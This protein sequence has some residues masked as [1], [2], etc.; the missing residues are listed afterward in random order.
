MW[1]H[2]QWHLSALLSDSFSTPF[3]PL[4]SP[5]SSGAAGAVLAHERTSGAASPQSVDIQKDKFK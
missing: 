3:N 5:P 4:L 1:Q 2:W